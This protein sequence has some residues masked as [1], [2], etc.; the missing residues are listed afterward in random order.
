MPTLY[1]WFDPS[2]KEHLRAF[3][4]LTETG[5]WP[6]GFVPKEVDMGSPWRVSIKIADHYMTLMLND[7]GGKAKR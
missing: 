1:E 3:R 4:T 6:K 5:Q 2:N 7:G